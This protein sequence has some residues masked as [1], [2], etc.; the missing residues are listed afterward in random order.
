MRG[1]RLGRG[2]PGSSAP[3]RPRRPDRLAGARGATRRSARP[4]TRCSTTSRSRWPAPRA[5]GSPTPT[6][7]AIS[8]PTTTCPCVGHGHPRVTAAIA[9]QSRGAQ[10]EHALPPPRRDRARRAAGRDLPAG[11]RHRAVRQL[12]L[13]GQRPGLADGDRRSPATRGGLCTDFAYH[14]ITEATAALSPEG[15]LDAAGRRTSRPG[16]R[17]TPTAARTST[18]GFAGA[19]RPPGRS[20]DCRRRPRS[21]TALV[22]SDGIADLDPAYVQELVGSPTTPAACGSPTR[23]RR[24]H[25]RTGDGD[26]VL[27]ALRDRPGLRHARQADGQR[28]PGRAPSSPAAT[29]PPQLVGRHHALQHLRR[30]PGE[31][32]RRRSPCSTSSRTSACSTA[33]SATGD[34]LR[35]ALRERRGR[36]P[37][38]GDVR[39]VGPGLG[40]RVRRRPRDREPDGPRRARG[41]RR[42]ARAAASSSAPPARHGNVLKIRPP[43]ALTEEHV[44]TL[45]EAFAT[46]VSDTR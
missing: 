13:G 15:W 21:S 28:P 34:A 40:R 3:P 33:C 16:R 42:D 23:S 35:A 25:G 41:P 44:P 38:I 29:S 26:V 37:A 39:G 14:G 27:R 18:A 24:G 2:R 30:Q 43:L 11:A 4:S 10:H 5:S 19:L 20:R 12:R 7:G 22:T 45:A 1:D 17:P 6:A 36:D 9:R 8:T 32:R 31:R 46:A